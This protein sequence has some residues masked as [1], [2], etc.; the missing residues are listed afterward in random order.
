MREEIDDAVKKGILMPA[1]S[2]RLNEEEEDDYKKGFVYEKSPEILT[3]GHFAMITSLGV[4]K[5]KERQE[6][7]NYLIAPNKFKFEKVVR[8]LSIVRK[9]IRRLQSKRT[10][11]KYLDTNMKFQM[12]FANQD[13]GSKRNFN[14]IVKNSGM[15]FKGKYFVDLTDE[16]IS[17]SLDY[18]FR[19]GSKEVSRFCKSKFVRKIAIE[20][21]G[22]LFAKSRIL[23]SQRFQ[24]AG[25]L[26]KLD[27]IAEFGMKLMTPVLDR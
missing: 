19:K 26:E 12:F 10:R 13:E 16:D 21:D 20:K 17:W 4:E 8:I 1:K 27:G 2:L 15:Q 25:G 23:D 6:F 24:A 5:V 22:I 14:S 11:T 9:F 18:L 3:P 7:S